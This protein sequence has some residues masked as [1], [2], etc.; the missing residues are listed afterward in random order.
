[1]VL[2][3]LIYPERSLEEILDKQLE[4]GDI[5]PLMF[6]SKAPR[7]TKTVIGRYTAERVNRFLLTQTGETIGLYNLRTGNV[8][9]VTNLPDSKITLYNDFI[10]KTVPENLNKQAYLEMIESVYSHWT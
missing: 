3:K 10:P 9:K 5:L 8:G 2:K 4:R 1:M 7:S 6:T